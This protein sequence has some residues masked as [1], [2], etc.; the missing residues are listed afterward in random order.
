MSVS[1]DIAN[2]Q[3]KAPFLVRGGRSFKPGRSLNFSTVKRGAHLKGKFISAG[4]LFQ[5]IALLLHN[6]LL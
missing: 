5:I 6:L 2:F 4:E 1:A 3:M